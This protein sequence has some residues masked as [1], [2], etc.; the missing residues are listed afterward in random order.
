MII[1]NQVLG[2]ETTFAWVGFE[3]A[4]LES[5]Y[6]PRGKSSTLD[7]TEVL[8]L[9]YDIGHHKKNCFKDSLRDKCWVCV[10]SF[11]TAEDPL[12]KDLLDW[13]MERARQ[14][15]SLDHPSMCRYLGTL[16]AESQYSVLVLEYCA[17]RSLVHASTFCCFRFKKDSF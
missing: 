14:R 4:E 6:T 3:A 1:E 16:R 11:G 17:N 12:N 2:G 15:V 9:M 13:F 7:S 5:R 8:F 10:I